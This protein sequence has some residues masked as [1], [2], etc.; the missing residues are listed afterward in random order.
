[1][2]NKLF[3]LLFFLCAISSYAQKQANI[4]YFGDNAGVNFNS[5]S[6]VALL[7]GQM[8]ILEGCASIADYNGNLL[9]YTDGNKIWNRNHAVMQ[10]GTGL[11]GDNSSTQS[12]VIVPHPSDQN[13]YYVFTV[14][15]CQNG[16]ANGI[17]YSKVDMTLAS[18]MGA[19]VTT[20]KN[21]LLVTTNN[22]FGL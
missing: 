19:V 2:K 16:L 9:F 6:P 12:A 22:L 14:D 8:S 11:M 17:R 13:I 3:F 1:M 21:I 18:G 7:N 10:N 20:E 5:G 15:A 4:W